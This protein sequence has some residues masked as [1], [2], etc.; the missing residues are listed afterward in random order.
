[1]VPGT[2]SDIAALLY[3][4]GTLNSPIDVVATMNQA[5]TNNG[6]VST[7]GIYAG[8][9]PYTAGD[10]PDSNVIPVL[11]RKTHAFQVVSSNTLSYSIQMEG[12]LDGV[13]WKIVGSAVTTDGITQVASPSLFKYVRFHLTA[14]SEVGSPNGALPVGVYV[15]YLA[16]P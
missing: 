6:Y 3:A 5:Q 2:G 7:V 16:T 4:Y 13:D 14:W 11:G 10:A 8:P 9:A 12:S 1:M 15:K